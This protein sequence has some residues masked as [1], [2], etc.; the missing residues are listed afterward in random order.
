MALADGFVR[1]ADSP[2]PLA[3][4]DAKVKKLIAILV[5]A[6]ATLA[7]TGARVE[8]QGVHLGAGGVHLDVGRTHIRHVYQP[9]YVGVGH[10]H[11]QGYGGDWRAY[12]GHGNVYGGSHSDGLPRGYSGHFDHQQYAPIHYDY[13]S[14]GHLE[15]HH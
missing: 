12:P 8:A 2:R 4:G 15:Y 5:T 13:R 1:D 10:L 11:G 6:G 9:N 7:L 14:Q 3:Q